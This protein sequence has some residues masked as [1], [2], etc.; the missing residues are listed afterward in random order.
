M[1]DARSF[2]G[3]KGLEVD[4]IEERRLEELAVEDRAGDAEERLVGEDDGAFRDG[5]DADFES[6]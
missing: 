2:S 6:F 4:E 3:Y 5:I 1:A